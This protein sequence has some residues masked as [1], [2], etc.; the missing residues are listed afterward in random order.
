MTYVAWA[1]LYEGWTDAAY[2]DV[3]IPRVMEDI[4][5]NCGVRH[6]DIAEFPTV[7]LKRDRVDAVATE[8]CGRREGFHLVFFHAD[9]GGRGQED[10][11]QIHASSFC[12]A[13]H[14][15]CNWPPERCIP[16]LPRRETEAWVLADP[17]AVTMA[18]GYRGSPESV[19]LP[20]NA[21]ESERVQDPKSILGAAIA[22]VRGRRRSVDADQILPAIALRQCLRRLRDAPSFVQFEGHLK[23]ALADLGCI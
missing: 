16:V 13:M 18:L 1:A 9:I 22:Q 12:R 8:A 3:L 4:I 10:N 15:L 5:L 7:R 11:Q 23:A 14:Q 19:G 6:S 20:A 21:A 17:I 2:F